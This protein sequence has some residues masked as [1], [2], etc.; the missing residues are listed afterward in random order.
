M[1][2]HDKVRE[3]A[4]TSCC[5]YKLALSSQSVLKLKSTSQA[6]LQSIQ[7]CLA[8]MNIE[9]GRQSRGTSPVAA[10]TNHT[11]LAQSMNAQT[12]SQT[13]VGSASE[14]PRNLTRSMSATA[15]LRRDMQNKRASAVM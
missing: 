9:M 10:T 12:N 5:Q 3:R 14:V 1:S 11:P 4:A 6:G 13:L 8:M 15:Q 2:C 7:D